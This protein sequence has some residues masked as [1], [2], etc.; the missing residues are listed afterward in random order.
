MLRRLPRWMSNRRVIRRGLYGIACFASLILIFYAEEDWRGKRDWERYKREWEAK[1]ER[2]DFASF[3]P[4]AV[5]DDQN[6]A[7]TPIVASTYGA[8]LDRH[9]RRIDPPNTNVMNRLDFNLDMP[10]ATFG[11][12]NDFEGNWQYGV[13]ADLKFFQT[14]YRNPVNTNWDPR[15]RIYANLNPAGTVTNFFPKAPQPQSLAAD[16]LLALSKDK[17]A[18]EELRQAARLPHSR[19]PLNYDA[20]PFIGIQLPN[21]S[22]LFQCVAVL[23]I[24]AIAELENGQNEK[25]LDDVKLM[26]YLVNSVRDQPFL[27]SYSLSF[28][29]SALQPLWEGLVDRRWSDAQLAVIGQVLAKFNVLSEYQFS[30]RSERVRA[31]DAVDYLERWRSLHE[32][33]KASFSVPENEEEFEP[34][35]ERGLEV[36]EL[37]LM[38]KGWFFLNDLAIADTCQQ[39]LRTDAEVDRGVFSP[40]IAERHERALSIHLKQLPPGKFF[41][42]WLYMGSRHMMQRFA[43]AQSSLDRARVACAMERYRLAHGE[44]PATLDLLAPQF[45]D[46]VPH[47]LINDQPLHYRRT[48]DGHFLLYSVGWNGTDDGGIVVRERVFTSTRVDIEKGDWVW[49]SRPGAV[50]SALPRRPHHNTRQ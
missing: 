45:I 9:G 29:N 34:G 42:S 20:N 22:P 7:L 26:L 28:I 39:S 24:R 43:F 47:D 27:T 6:F 46:K 23:R 10:V 15:Y 32:I 49:P 25:A 31:I 11:S 4:A 48:D 5:P 19:F 21:I 16:V 36:T 12:T 30:M 38:P 13:K 44:Y 17:A 35:W 8:Y 2:F 37:Y 18:I 40:E 50:P 33:C 3:V 41:I 14:Y 1:G